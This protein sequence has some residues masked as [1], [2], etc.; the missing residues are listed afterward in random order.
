MDRSAVVLAGGFSSRFSQDKALLELDGKPLVNCVIDAVSSVVDEVILVV[1]TPERAKQYAKL[2]RTNVKFAVDSEESKGILIDALTGLKAAQGKY[3]VL[4]PSD[5]PLVSRDVLELLFELCQGKTAA[6][7]RWPNEQVEPLHS[8]YHSKSAVK[9]AEIAVE[10][11]KLDLL[12]MIENLGGVRYVSTLVVQEF[13]PELKTFFKIN[14]P[15]DL[16]MAETLSKP[17]R[18]KA[19]KIR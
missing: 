19:N 14:T 12:S 1:N 11:G 7:P 6:V 13:D 17:K 2:V 3:C 4:L 16:K 15:I 9:A 10:E 5:T 18:T 8:V